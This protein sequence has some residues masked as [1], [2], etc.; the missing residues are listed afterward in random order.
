MTQR[1]F[2]AFVVLAILIVARVVSA[3]HYEADSGEAVKAAVSKAKSGDQIVLAD[4]VYR[5]LHIAFKGEGTE[6]APIVLRAQTPGGVVLNGTGSIRVSGTHLVVSGFVFDQLWQRNSV[7]R[8]DRAQ[9]CQLTECAFI[10]CGDPLNTYRHIVTLR[11]GSC[12]NRLDHCFMTGSL[13]MGMGI[14]VGGEKTRNTDNRIDHNWYKDIRRRSNNGQEVIQLANAGGEVDV[15]AIVEYCLF[16]ATDGDAEII[17]DKSC[18]NTIRYNTFRDSRCQFVLRDGSRTLVQG[19]IFLNTGGIRVHGGHHRIVSNYLADCRSS[20][21]SMPGGGWLK[22]GRRLYMNVTDCL[23]AGNTIVNAGRAGLDVGSLNSHPALVRHSR[24]CRNRYEKNLVVGTKGV[25]IKDGGSIDSTWTGNIVAPAGK[26]TAGLAH[27]GIQETDVA[28]TAETGCLFPPA[29]LKAGCVQ[30]AL[31]M[32]GRPLVPSDVGPTW[33][34]GD[35]ER[36]RRAPELRPVPDYKRG[37]KETFALRA[38][39]AAP[40]QLQQNGA[41]TYTVQLEDSVTSNGAA[42]VELTEGARGVRFPKADARAEARLSLPPGSYRAVIHAYAT[43]SDADAFYVVLNGAKVRTY[44]VERGKVSVC[45][46]PVEFTVKPGQAASLVVVP[47]EMGVTIDRLE[48]E[49]MKNRGRR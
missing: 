34:G 24:M 13:S 8:L 7:V 9:H 30:Q 26:A 49:P 12:H 15:R 22:N 21:I 27:E 17:S 16:E 41:G 5:G 48:I 36:I 45:K 32:F 29:E 14:S 38:T 18:S 4:G 33:M 31:G 43:S 42:V 46:S 10:E 47:A 20:G 3:A 37:Q 44:P 2:P 35:R 40:L 25:M 39:E 19:N 28:M 11:N 1:P 6:E 23:V